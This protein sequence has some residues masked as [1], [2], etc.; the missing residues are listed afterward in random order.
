[1]LECAAIGYA[2][3][4]PNIQRHVY[5]VLLTSIDAWKRSSHAGTLSLV[6]SSHRRLGTRACDGP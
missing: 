3:A 1:M 4:I 5:L 6:I 2:A